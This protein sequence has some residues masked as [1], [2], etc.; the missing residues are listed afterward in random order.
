MEMFTQAQ[1]M[2]PHAQK[3]DLDLGAKL[4]RIDDCEMSDFQRLAALAEDLGYSCHMQR[5]EGSVWFACYVYRDETVTLSFSSREQVVRLIAET[6]SA[7]P[8]QE[9]CKEE[10]CEPLVTQVRE[11]YFGFDCGMTYVIRLCD[12][13]FVLIDSGMGEFD[14]AEH[15]LDILQKQNVLDSK[16]VIALWFITHPHTDHFLLFVKLMKQY[17][18]RFELQRLAYN[19]A[20]L[21]MASAPSDLP[22]F[23][24]VIAQLQ[25]VQRITVRSGQHYSLGGAVFD[26]LYAFDDMLPGYIHGL[27]ITSIVMRME[28]G[29]RRFLWLGDAMQLVADYICSRYEEDSLRCEIMQ[30]GHHGYSGGSD[31]LYRIV[32]PEYLL[33][34]C[35]NFWYPVVSLWP[36]NVYLMESERIRSIY[37]GGREETVLEL[38]KPLP[39]SMPYKRFDSCKPGDVLYHEDFC[40]MSPYQLFFSCITGGSTGYQPL[41]LVLPGDGSCSLQSGTCYSVCEFLQ[42]GQMANAPSFTLTIT[43][44][45]GEHC[46]QFGLFWNYEKP[47][48]WSDEHAL[49]IG[50]QP[51][52]PFT[53]KLTAD[54]V[55]GTAELYC[56][57]VLVQKLAYQPEKERG[58]YLLMRNAAVVL[59]EITVIKN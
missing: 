25:G 57:D 9:V 43:G 23:N 17:R 52:K 37:V 32:D 44:C 56:N 30:V 19:W 20:P 22:Q 8:P 6:G 1:V 5:Q 58:L 28:L 14:E 24:E 39:E 51:G 38:T 4:L 48:V 33:W 36:S 11:S 55:S 53:A 42:P 45:A 15:L 49:W 47:T 31:Q 54:A 18:D 12:G 26:V 7:L 35:P 29:G 50:I 16:P 10:L 2:F 59:N 46:E 27:N 21:E 34:P 40:G 41:E 13:R 3:C